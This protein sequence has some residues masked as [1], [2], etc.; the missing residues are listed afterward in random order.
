M[1]KRWTAVAFFLALYSVSAFLMIVFVNAGW[2]KFSDS[3]GWARAFASWGFPV[4]FRLLVGGI[5]VLGGVLLLVPR[6]AIYAAA[7]LA[8][9]MLGAMGTHIAHGDP[10]AIHHEAAPLVLLGAVMYMHWRRKRAARPPC[11]E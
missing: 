10:A 8:I 6:T 7:A 2:P 9:I 4:W 1:R 11:C 3:S 5:E